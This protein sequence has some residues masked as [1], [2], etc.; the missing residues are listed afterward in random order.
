MSERWS[1]LLHENMSSLRRGCRNG[2]GGN[3]LGYLFHSLRLLLAVKYLWY[4]VVH[5]DLGL[6]LL[7]DDA[8]H[9]VEEAHLG[10][11]WV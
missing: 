11:W 1:H 3:T 10:E 9:P 8:E 7:P 4:V 6:A 5:V 2:L